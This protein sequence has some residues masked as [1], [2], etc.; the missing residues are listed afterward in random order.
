MTKTEVP[1]AASETGPME[2]Q[3]SVRPCARD[4][5]HTFSSHSRYQWMATVS[6]VAGLPDI[7]AFGWDSLSALGLATDELSIQNEELRQAT[8][9]DEVAIKLS[10]YS[11]NEMLADHHP[12]FDNFQLE[13]RG[14]DSRFFTLSEHERQK[15]GENIYCILYIFRRDSA[16][17]V[18]RFIP[19]ETQ[20]WVKLVE[21]DGYGDARRNGR[22]LA[23]L[24]VRDLVAA[25]NLSPVK[26]GVAT[27]RLHQGTMTISA[28]EEK[29]GGSATVT[30]DVTSATVTEDKI[31]G[32]QAI[33]VAHFMRYAETGVY[34]TAKVSTVA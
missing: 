7:S 29:A 21:G 5:K 8:C 14:S 15:N 24:S 3:I 2:I 13:L 33:P 6:G 32:S 22:V 25:L 11:L 27:L 30:A 17:G 12:D 4:E 23:R 16:A 10:L 18:Y 19:Y 9:G 34:R 31:E 26:T 20:D 28:S 1:S